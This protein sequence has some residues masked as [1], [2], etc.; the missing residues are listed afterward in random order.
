[1]RYLAHLNKPCMSVAGLARPPADRFSRKKRSGHARIYI[2][3]HDVALVLELVLIVI[4]RFAFSKKL[5]K[6]LSSMIDTPAV[7]LPD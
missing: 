5:G 7:C 2:T 3:W 6:E 4:L 1:M